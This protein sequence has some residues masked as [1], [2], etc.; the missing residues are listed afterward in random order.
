MENGIGNY[1]MLSSADLSDLINPSPAPAPAASPEGIIV[2]AEY[3]NQFYKFKLRLDDNILKLKII[4]DDEIYYKE[5]STTDSFWIENS[6]FFQDNYDKFCTIMKKV[7]IDRNGD[8]K[9]NIIKETIDKIK[10]ELIHN[11]I[12]DFHIHFIVKKQEDKIDLMQQEIKSLK[13][14]NIRLQNFILGL[15]NSDIGD[16]SVFI[17]DRST[18]HSIRNYSHLKLKDIWKKNYDVKGYLENPDIKYSS[19]LSFN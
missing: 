5:I 18:G 8:I 9:L 15:I 7:F 17:I 13:N 10:V 11:G 16:Q 6:K 19:T 4:N 3:L 2:K 1:S 12:F 14:E